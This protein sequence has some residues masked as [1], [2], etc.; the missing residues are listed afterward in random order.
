[1]LPKKKIKIAHII[2][3]VKVPVDHPSYLYFAQPVT[4]QSMLNA[5]KYVT[6]RKFLNIDVELYTTQYPE[7]REIIPKGFVVT[8]DLTASIHNF[9]KFENKSKKLPR[10]KDIINRLYENST[11]EYFIYTNAD[12]TLEPRFY[13]RIARLLRGGY[14]AL[15][16]HRCDVPK[17]V[18]GVRINVKNMDRLYHLITQDH[19]GH[20]C[21]VFKRVWVPKIDTG[22][23]FVGYLP[24]GAVLKKQILR[25]ATKFKELDSTLRLTFHLGSDQSWA[26]GTKNSNNEYK[27]K[28]KMLAR[29]VRR[30]KPA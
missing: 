21:F 12:I 3:P 9:V 7:D 14:D 15:C 1:M 13:A 2:N 24:V 4:F 8:K 27:M 17:K 26:N 20:D 28:N 6:A 5:K 22:N 23:V 29:R 10:I 19:P 30:G 25:F 18:D 16:I 11:A